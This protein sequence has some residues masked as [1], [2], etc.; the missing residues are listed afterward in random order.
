MQK[1]PKWLR[2]LLSLT[3]LV[4]LVMVICR[5]R[6]PRTAPTTKPAPAP[7]TQPVEGKRLPTYEEFL[8][9]FPKH[10]GTVRVRSILGPPNYSDTKDDRV[11]WHYVYRDPYCVHRRRPNT[12]T[13]FEFTED[14]EKLLRVKIYFGMRGPVVDFDAQSRRFLRDW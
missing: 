1:I 13:V 8:K 14:G 3:V 9:Q 12:G 10:G 7:S 5:A 2:F 11:L 6:L 4:A